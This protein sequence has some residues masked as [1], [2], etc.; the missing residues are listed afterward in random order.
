MDLR[1][2]KF[3]LL[4]RIFFYIRK[5]L[6]NWKQRRKRIHFETVRLYSFSKMG[7][8]RLR[9]KTCQFEHRFYGTTQFIA[10]TDK[11]RNYCVFVLQISPGIC[12]KRQISGICCYKLFHL[13]L[14]SNSKQMM[15]NELHFLNFQKLYRFYCL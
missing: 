1:K 13:K 7:P 3:L 2:K 12:K 9:R 8:L 6:V 10:P 15:R 5:A 11:L 14:F 4:W